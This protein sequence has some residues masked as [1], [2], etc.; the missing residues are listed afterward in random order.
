[1]LRPS[2]RA[3]TACVLL[4]AVATATL[5]AGCGGGGKAKQATLPTTSTT[6]SASPTPSATAAIAQIRQNWTQFFDGS[7]SAADRIR[8]LENGEKFKSVIDALG[9]SS[10]AKQVKARVKRVKLTGATTASVT[11]TI[12]LSGKPVLA[13]VSGQAVL[14]DGIWKV[15]EA[16]VCGLAKLEGA[17]PA[18]CA[19]T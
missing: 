1:M 19:G 9:S 18:A 5:L 12:L 16:S 7:T 3:R 10:L 6:A 15:G 4:L 17:A 2:V 8:L 13:N 14:V 11:Y